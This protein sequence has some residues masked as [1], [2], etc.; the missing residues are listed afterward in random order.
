M[1]SGKLLM[2]FMVGVVFVVVI[3]FIFWS[4]KTG[5]D[6]L[7]NEQRTSDE[8]VSGQIEIDEGFQLIKDGINYVNMKIVFYESF[9][10]YWKEEIAIEYGRYFPNGK[11]KDIDTQFMALRQVMSLCS[12]GKDLD[13][14]D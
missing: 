14:V 9:Y 1:R 3:S 7:K 8:P 5:E 12:F 4:W 11:A 6:F 2:V 10:H 13:N